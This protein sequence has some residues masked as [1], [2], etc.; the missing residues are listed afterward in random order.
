MVQE[1]NPD[2][3]FEYITIYNVFY[4]DLVSEKN[5]RSSKKGKIWEMDERE[6][7]DLI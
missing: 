6:P 2:S 4:R 1:I 3:K 7:K 5:G